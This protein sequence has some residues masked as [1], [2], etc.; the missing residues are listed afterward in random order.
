MIIQTKSGKRVIGIHGDQLG[1]WYPY[2]EIIPVKKAKEVMH[3][4]KNNMKIFI[5]KS[6]LG[7]INVV[8][9]QNNRAAEYTYAP[10]IKSWTKWNKKRCVWKPI[11]HTKLFREIEAMVRL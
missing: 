6:S 11:K 5:Y 9:L 10:S 3:I 1:V 4:K 7:R 8:I 2:S